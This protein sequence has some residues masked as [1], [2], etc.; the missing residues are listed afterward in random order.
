MTTVVWR[1]CVAATLCSSVAFGQLPGKGGAVDSVKVH[2]LDTVVVTPERSATSIR[3]STV[4]VTVLSENQL[5]QLPL[6][7]VAASLS[8]APGV[9][10]LDANSVGGSP[11]I[12]ARGFYGGGETD[13]VPALVDG[14]PIA[15]L[16]SGDY[17][18]ASP[19]GIRIQNDD[20]RRQRQ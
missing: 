11:R 9:V 13:Y 15:A 10:V 6:R 8:L 5:R 18:W 4:A 2:S 17:P 16:G 1:A 3:A 12:I 14:V 7:S 20:S 19:D